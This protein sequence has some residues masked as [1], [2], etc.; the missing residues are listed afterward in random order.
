MGG[1]GE[2]SVKYLL[3]RHVYVGLIP[4]NRKKT[5]QKTTPPKTNKQNQNPQNKNNNKNKNP[6]I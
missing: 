4:G 5:R 3:Y 1:V 6:I 2:K